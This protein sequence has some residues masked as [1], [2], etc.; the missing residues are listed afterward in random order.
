ML[1]VIDPNT[2]VLTI[3]VVAVPF[4]WQVSERRGSAL[5]LLVVVSV[6]A[7]KKKNDPDQPSRPRRTG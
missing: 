5:S 3:E 4:E 1:P 2:A 6:V 7:W